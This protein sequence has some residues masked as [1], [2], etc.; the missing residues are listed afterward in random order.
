MITPL[1]PC[2]FFTPI[3]IPHASPLLY[4]TLR[5]PY[6]HIPRRTLISPYSITSSDPICHSI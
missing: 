1:L 4:V 6:A 3:P 5:M 2:I